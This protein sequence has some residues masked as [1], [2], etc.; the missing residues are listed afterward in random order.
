[1]GARGHRPRVFWCL[2]LFAVGGLLGTHGVDACAAAITGAGDA[3]L[4]P[5]PGHEPVGAAPD[6]ADDIAR[7]AGGGTARHVGL[8]HVVAMCTVVLVTAATGTLRRLSA[9]VRAWSA[10]ARVAA[11]GRLARRRELFRPPG[12]G[13]VEL[14]VLIC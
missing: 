8:G 5:M 11:A 2:L 12:P 1:M 13:R 9:G 4:S 14:C 7:P 3:A 6:E 10:H